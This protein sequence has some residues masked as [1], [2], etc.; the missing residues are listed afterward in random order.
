MDVRCGLHTGEVT[1]RAGDIAGIAV[2]IGAR[3]CPRQ[4]A[5]RGPGHAD[6]PRPGGRLR[7]RVR[8]AGRTHAQGRT[9]APGAVRRAPLDVTAVFRGHRGPRQG[10]MT[11]PTWLPRA[12]MVAS[13]ASSTSRTSRVKNSITRRCRSRPE[14]E[15]E[16]GVQ[17][18]APCLLGSRKVGLGGCVHH[19]GRSPSRQHAV[20][21][22]RRP[23]SRSPRSTSRTPCAPACVPCPYAAEPPPRRRPPKRLRRPAERFAD[24]FQD[25]VVDLG[26]GLALREDS[27][28]IVLH[29]PK[30]GCITH[31]PIRARSS[32]VGRE[33]HHAHRWAFVRRSE[34]LSRQRGSPRAPGQT[35]AAQRS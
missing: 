21:G 1:R 32:H 7:P 6:R 22:P 8:R 33:L 18:G 5:R 26:R 10:T 17:S 11:V 19:P 2:H 34:R 28:N 27:R 30:V 9:R 14:R 4:R 23:R 20:G 16:A 31:V 3:V 12:S 24:R 15:R 13:S 29:S 35:R 25:R